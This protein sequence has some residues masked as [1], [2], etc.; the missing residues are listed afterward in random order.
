M[1]IIKP[2]QPA[3]PL[4]SNRMPENGFVMHNPVFGKSSFKPAGVTIY[5]M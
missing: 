3:K 5:N 1:I 4:Q 2:E